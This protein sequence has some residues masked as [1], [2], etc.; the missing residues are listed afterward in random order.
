MGDTKE[1]QKPQLLYVITARNYDEQKE[2]KEVTNDNFGVLRI[3]SNKED[4]KAYMLQH[5]NDT[6]LEHCYISMYENK[7]GRLKITVSWH[8]DVS[9]GTEQAWLRTE[10]LECQTVELTNSLK[11]E[12]STVM[13]DI[14]AVL[15]GM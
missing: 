4:A 14:A 2:T 3:F 5:Y 13:D 1:I 9:L 15:W 12:Y 6:G 7:Q 11:L 10:T 8:D